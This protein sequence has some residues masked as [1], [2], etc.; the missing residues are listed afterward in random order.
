MPTRR[1]ERRWQHYV[2]DKKNRAARQPVKPNRKPNGTRRRNWAKLGYNDADDLDMPQTER[3]MPRGERERRQRLMAAAKPRNSEELDIIS[4][5]RARAEG[6]TARG[7][8]VEVSTGL[9]RVEVDGRTILCSVRGSLSAADSGFTNVVAVGDDVLV[10]RDGRDAGVVETVL[11]R[12]SVLLRPDVFHGH[13]QQV[14]VANADQVLI[15]GSWKNPAL[16]FELVDR[17]LITAERNNLSA[18]ICVNKID[19]ADDP[20]EYRTALRPYQALGYGVLFTSATRGDGVAELRGLLCGKTT[21]VAGLSGVGKSSLLTAVQPELQLRTGAVNED[22]HEGRHVT[23]QVH[24]L[25]LQGGGYAVDTPGIREFG[26]AGLRR[27]DLARFYPE[28]N[29]LRE[30]CTFGD[31]SHTHE[32][33]CVVAAAVA[34]GPVSATRFHSYGKIWASLPD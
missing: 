26:L 34:Q 31:C 14:I 9:C 10:S 3:V 4:A 13:L 2:E 16:W 12:R 20:A 17:Y 27:A 19:L 5:P 22:R 6:T 21:A 33:G 25:R 32:P 1:Q 28:I 24:L 29:A 7:T 30:Q 11:P 15:V 8:V 23:T 18:V